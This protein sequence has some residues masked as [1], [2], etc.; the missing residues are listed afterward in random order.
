MTIRDRA[1]HLVRYLRIAPRCIQGLSQNRQLTVTGAPAHFPPVAVARYALRTA[2]ENDCTRISVRQ[3]P[4][5]RVD[6]DVMDLVETSRNDF[7]YLARPEL[8]L[9][10]ATLGTMRQRAAGN[11]LGRD[12]PLIVVPGTVTAT[13]VSS[14][15]AGGKG[16]TLH[17]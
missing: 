16:D 3:G 2:L 9:V 13:P 5:R 10:P 1:L 17:V 12:R 15:T 11:E 14:P 4:H 7:G 8:K 6:F